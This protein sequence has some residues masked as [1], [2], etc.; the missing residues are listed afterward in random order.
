MVSTSRGRGLE[1]G[2]RG[3]SAC[4]RRLGEEAAAK[5]GRGCAAA[6]APP[7]SVRRGVSRPRTH[8]SGAAAVA[9]ARELPRGGRKGGRRCAFGGR[10]ER[11]RRQ[12]AQKSPPTRDGARAA[13]VAPR[14]HDS[15]GL[16]LAH[17]GEGAPGGRQRAA[18]AATSPDALRQ[19]VLA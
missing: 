13:R 17:R 9:E 15:A 3:A 4:G 1:G 5:S 12:A 19:A 18:G 7:R 16:D 2:S 11:P 14:G 10:G 6:G 8:L